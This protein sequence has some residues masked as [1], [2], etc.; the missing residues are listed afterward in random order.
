VGTDAVTKQQLA[1]VAEVGALLERGGFDYWLFGG[2]A[3]DFYV[4]S[5]TRAHADVDIA[6]WARDF[7]AIVSLLGD[8]GWQH[9]PAAGEQG[10]TGYERGP[11]RLELMR[12]VA[13][14]ARRVFIPLGEQRV[15]WSEQALGIEERELFDVRARVIPLSLL[16][17]GKA[18]PRGDA[19][20]A[21][22][23]RADIA[24]LSDLRG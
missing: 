22:K 3:V 19:V 5:I 4:G 24:I 6:V 2:W 12:L 11:V 17:A 9:R 10:G 16:R 14:E 15:L 20:D 8:H 1:A 18:S 13:D 23:D 7:D 21:A